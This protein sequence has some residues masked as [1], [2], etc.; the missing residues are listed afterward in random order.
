MVLEV[1]EVRSIVKWEFVSSSY[2]IGFG[3]YVKTESRN[4]KT[5][6]EDVVSVCVCVCVCILSGPIHAHLCHTTYTCVCERACMHLCV[7]GGGRGTMMDLID[8][9]TGIEPIQ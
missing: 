3:M 1:V 4:G 2:D 9:R 6:K 8:N 5:H 7:W